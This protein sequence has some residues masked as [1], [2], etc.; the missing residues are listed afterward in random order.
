MV[1]LRAQPGS[2]LSLFATLCVFSSSLSM[3]FFSR[4]Q[5]LFCFLTAPY[6][7]LIISVC[8]HISKGSTL[9]LC[10][11]SYRLLEREPIDQS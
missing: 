8:I 10:P 5:D 2:P 4:V 1:G 9:L 7:Q 11:P 6:K 3:T